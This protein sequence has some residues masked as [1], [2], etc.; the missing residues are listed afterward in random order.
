MVI[1]QPRVVWDGARAFV[2]AAYHPEFEDFA[3]RVIT[4]LGPD[5]YGELANTRQRLLAALVQ[6]GGDR[7][8]TD[9]ETG[10]WRV[11]LDELL[12]SRPDLT[13]AVQDL[14]SIALEL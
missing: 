12:R 9:L 3:G 4:R 7:G 8:P 2:F 1:H 6:T 5:I 10:R 13:P 14:T 11:R